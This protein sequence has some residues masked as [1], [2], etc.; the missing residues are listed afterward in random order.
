VFITRWGE[1]ACLTE[2]RI[3]DAGERLFVKRGYVGT[4]LL[5]VAELAGVAPRT[6]YVRFG[7]KARLLDRCIG[8]SVTGEGPTAD[9][10]NGAEQV[11][12]TASTLEARIAA[13]AELS[14]GIMARSAALLA[15]GAQAA[16]MEPSIAE[17]ETAGLRTSLNHLRRFAK[18]LAADGMLPDAVTAED[19]ADILWA[20]A[21]PRGLVSFAIDRGWSRQRYARWLGFT[22]RLLLQ[23][24]IERPETAD[25][26]W[27]VTS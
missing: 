2:Q 7:T 3:I 23:A 22:L 15:V 1:P 19:L 10:D 4:S 25:G 13:L 20:L 9:A 14:S 6:V 16:A 11:A 21:G 12:L 8:A 18:K 27:G 5:A 26:T 24:E 17:M